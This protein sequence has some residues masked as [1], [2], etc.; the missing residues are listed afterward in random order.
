MGRKE[1]VPA[2]LGSLKLWSEKLSWERL[3]NF[4]FP[5]TVAAIGILLCHGWYL[6]VERAD[7]PQT[8]PSFAFQPK[9]KALSIPPEVWRNLRPTAGAYG[10]IKDSSFPLGSASYY[11]F[12]WRPVARNA[13]GHLHRP[14]ACMGGIGWRLARPVESR[15][16]SISGKEL[17]WYLLAFE[18]PDRKALQLW[19]VWKNHEPVPLDFQ[20]GPGAPPISWRELLTGKRRSGVEIVSCVIPYENREPTNEEMAKALQDA[21]AYHP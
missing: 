7:H 16:I 9:V 15:T 13:S 10:A 14:D 4:Q 18:K 8:T 11:H 17:S 1:V 3:P 6:W 21:F 19:G 2:P 5:L 12:F 20:Q